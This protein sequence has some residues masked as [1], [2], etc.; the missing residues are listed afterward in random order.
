MAAATYSNNL[1][2]TT[3]LVAL[4]INLRLRTS[5]VSCVAPAVRCRT[6]G[7]DAS[8]CHCATKCCCGWRASPTCNGLRPVESTCAR[9]DRVRVAVLRAGAT[10]DCT[11]D[12]EISNC[13]A[14]RPALKAA[15]TTF[16]LP[17]TVL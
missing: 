5:G 14:V 1:R 6:S 8:A 16:S 15:R 2:N 9:R 3:H 13:D 4:R 7:C 10:Y 12:C 11:Y 17:V